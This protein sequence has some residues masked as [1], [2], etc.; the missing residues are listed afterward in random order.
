MSIGMKKEPSA[1][2]EIVETIIKEDTSEGDLSA[3]KTSD[4]QDASSEL[5]IEATKFSEKVTSNQ[6]IETEVTDIKIEIDDML[7]SD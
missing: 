3:D 5:L 4:P 6:V 1:D 7:N 2:K